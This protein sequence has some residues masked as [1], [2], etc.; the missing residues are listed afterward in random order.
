VQLH[1]RHESA[2]VVEPLFAEPAA[3]T[4]WFAAMLTVPEFMGYPV[5]NLSTPMS[6]AACSS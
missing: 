2:F 3:G 1:V 6:D 5:K 4:G